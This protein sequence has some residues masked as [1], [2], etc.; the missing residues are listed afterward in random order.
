M[1]KKLQSFKLGFDTAAQLDW[2]KA[3]GYR[4]KTQAIEVAVAQLYAVERAYQEEEHEGDVLHGASET[5]GAV[6]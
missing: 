6:R 1:G 3:N 5:V 4:S 2:L